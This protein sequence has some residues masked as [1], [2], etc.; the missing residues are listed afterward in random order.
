MSVNLENSAV[1]TGLEKIR[2]HSQKL[3][4][5]Q[6]HCFQLETVNISI[7]FS[8]SIV[9]DSLQPLGLWSTP[10]FP[11]HRQLQELTQT[12]FHRVGEAIQPSHPLS[13]LFSPA[14]NFPSIRIFSNES[15]FPI[16]RPKYWSF[17]FSF[18]P[19]NEYSG[20]ITFRTDWL[21]LLAVQG[22]LNNLLQHHSS[23]PLIL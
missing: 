19:S 18:S 15:D 2:F 1:A 3:F 20:L 7:H 9:S 23:K 16:G 8:H 21:D 11:V 13:Y 17:S 5:L 14:F 6:V 4:H 12:H 10:G 22:T